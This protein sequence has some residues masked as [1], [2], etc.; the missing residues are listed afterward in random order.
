MNNRKTIKIV[1]SCSKWIDGEGWVTEVPIS[2]IENTFYIGKNI[3]VIDKQD[4][5]KKSR[6]RGKP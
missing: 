3:V 5:Q 2:Q 4:F 1:G 6:R